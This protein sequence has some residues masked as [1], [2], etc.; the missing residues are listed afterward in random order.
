[1]TDNWHH[2]LKT[3]GAII[4]GDQI[5]HY[6]NPRAELAAT[7]SGTVMVDLSHFSLLEFSGEDAHAFLQGQLSCDIRKIVS[8][9]SVSH[10]SYCTPKGRMLASFLIWKDEE[11][12]VMQLPSA[13]SAAIHKRL[14]M[15]VLRSKVTLTNNSKGAVCVGLA[16]HD[17]A[18]LIRQAGG[19]VPDND[20]GRTCNDCCQVVRLAQNR[21]M[22]V[23]AA[24]KAP[25]IWQHLRE[26]IT[27]VGAAC[28]DWL[29]IRAGI[30]VITPATQEQFV[31]QMT[32][33]EIIGGVSFDKG[34]YPGQ[35]IV[36]R[37]HYLGKTKRR[38]YLATIPSTSPVLAGDELFSDDMPEQSSGMIV[39]AS[40]APGEGY[41]V[42]A[43]L[44]TGSADTA[45][46]ICWKTPQGPALTML[47]LPYPVT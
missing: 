37:T 38:M 24:G 4:E 18:M 42:L 32:N 11:R 36:A 40:P 15:F 5:A 3:H 7:A 34:C 14:S 23:I 6:G 20:Q 30:P 17:A 29:T 16:G 39:N 35:E 26:H 12:Y 2:F 45:S 13:L 43:V 47:P 21:F 1:M 28:W 19:V 22:L 8:G 44:Q 10:G 46:R 27:P 33:L 25:A 9:K 41:D 31:P